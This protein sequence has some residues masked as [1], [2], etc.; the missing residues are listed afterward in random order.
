LAII[1]ARNSPA[2]GFFIFILLLLLLLLLLLTTVATTTATT[3]TTTTTLGEKWQRV[4]L[5]LP[6]RGVT[7]CNNPTEWMFL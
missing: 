4:E 3:T 5:Q 1:D 2:L 7:S 6:D